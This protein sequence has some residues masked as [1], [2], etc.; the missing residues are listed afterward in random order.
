MYVL[1]YFEDWGCQ[2]EPRNLGNVG[3]GGG[4]KKELVLHQLYKKQYT[5]QA[6]WKIGFYRPF[7]DIWITNT[8][9]KY[10][11]R[12]HLAF[13]STLVFGKTILG[14]VIENSNFPYSK[15]S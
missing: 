4:G 1:M 3:K 12:K 11:E 10:I 9:H 8:Q 7:M 13:N 2:A 5:G 6:L 14:F 15:R